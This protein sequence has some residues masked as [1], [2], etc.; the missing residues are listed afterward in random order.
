M[1]PSCSG[2]MC[3]ATS[4]EKSSEVVQQATCQTTDSTWGSHSGQFRF[5]AK[6]TMNQFREVGE[7]LQLAACWRQHENV[8]ATSIMLIQGYPVHIEVGEGVPGI[9]RG[10]DWGG[11]PRGGRIGPAA[12]GSCCSWGWVSEGRWFLFGP[13][14][15]GSCSATETADANVRTCAKHK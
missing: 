9:N 5:S 7:P 8:T 10:G 4:S 11:V 14:P 1:N 12:L 6:K 15:A 2:F 3:N 13:T